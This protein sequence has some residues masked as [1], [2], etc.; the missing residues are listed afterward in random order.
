MKNK[1]WKIKSGILLLSLFIFM[2]FIIQC[3]EL[4]DDIPSVDTACQAAGCHMS[5][6]LKSSLPA[7]GKHSAHLNLN[8]DCNYCHYNYL[9]N[10]NHKNGI[11]DFEKGARV[12]FFDTSKAGASA[13]FIDNT[14]T[15]GKFYCEIACHPGAPDADWY[16]AVSPNWDCSDCHK[17]SVGSRRQIFDSNGDGTGTGGDFNLASHHVIDYNNPNT[18]I[19]TVSDC[20]VCH[21]QASHT[22][23]PVRLK[24]KDNAGQVIVYDPATASSLET[25]CLSC[26]DNDG[27][28]TDG[29]PLSPFSSSNTLG[30]APNVRGAKIKESWLKS[31][32]HGPN[33][34]HAQEDRLTCMGTGQPGT[35]C[36]GN[37]GSIN[38][39]GSTFEVIAAKE[40]FYSVSSGDGTYNENW[41]SL[42][43]DCHSGYSGVTKED[44][45][46]V[47]D[48]GIL[49]SEAW[50]NQ[51][52]SC[53]S[54]SPTTNA[55]PPYYTSGITTHFA[56]HD[57]PGD[58]WGLNDGQ[59]PGCGFLYPCV[60]TDNNLHWLHLGMYDSFFR[61][62]ISVR[63]SGLVICSNC[64]S[65]HGSNT[66][67]G[68]VHDEMG[69]TN[70][71][72][73][74]GNT[75]GKMRDEAYN[76][77]YPGA[78]PTQNYLETY[79]TYCS[80]S[81]HEKTGPTRAWFSPLSE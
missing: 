76:E 56:D 46:G 43:F 23:G 65:V 64:H 38:A 35:G 78:D 8:Y 66:Q 44:I 5:T 32:G 22:S 47:K 28:V 34:N 73:G 12:V 77:S 30:T 75:H 10:S 58:P 49:D 11:N 15:T 36:H 6:I 55:Y 4:R 19:I 3:S 62:D 79:P 59:I 33:A 63:S 41:F 24:D 27:A 1:F 54:Y 69:Y 20:E 50:L 31:Y 39:H 14:D 26:H 45:L 71:T 80:M 72:D 70:I 61:G 29:T 81:C 60:P 67:Y 2:I 13:Y 40:Y 18:Q 7:T 53:H 74:N 57:E 21:D 16:T 68:A 37:N 42:C 25:F 17:S 51:C 48:N 52:G 9:N